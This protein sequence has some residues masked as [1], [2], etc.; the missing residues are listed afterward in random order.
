MKFQ[1]PTPAAAVMAVL[2]GAMLV[3]WAAVAPPATAQVGVA[4]PVQ[5]VPQ[6]SAANCTSAPSGGQ[7]F[8]GQLLEFP[9]FSRMDLTNANFEGATLKGAVFIGANLTGA[10]FRNARFVDTASPVRTTD[11]SFAR[12]DSACFYHASFAA[13]TYFTYATLTCT[14][15]SSTDLAGG[16]AI[17]GD[18]PLRYSMAPDGSCRTAFRQSSMNCEFV[19]DWRNFDLSGARVDQCRQ[20]LADRDFSNAVMNGLNFSSMVLDGSNFAGAN[21][22]RAVFT[23]ASLQ[24]VAVG[25]AQQC[26]DMSKAQLQGAELSRANLTGATLAGAFLSSNPDAGEPNAASFTSAHLK[27][28]NLSNAHLSGVDFSNANFF[29][30]LGS[31][32]SGCGTSGGAG[33][34]VNCATASGAT[35]TGTKFNGAYLYGVDFSGATISGAAFD[36]AVLVGANFSAAQISTDSNTATRTSFSRAYL[37]GTNLDL[38]KSLEANLSDAFL[39]FNGSGNVMNVLLNGRNHNVFPCP[40]SGCNPATVANVCVRAGY[41]L[42]T[43]PAGNTLITCPDGQPAGSGCGDARASIDPLGP[44]RRWQSSI[45]IRNPPELPPAWYRNDATYTVRTPSTDAAFC[46]GPGNPP[47]F[48]W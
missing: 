32:P 14:D 16:Q 43:V 20:Q 34:T 6:L 47:V 1:F 19:D 8:S 5:S 12:L 29:G 35:M 28:V 46:G 9:N 30:T 45:D 38:A 3:L 44:N 21:L 40:A 23:G 31:N 26:V 27:N 36:G 10:S 41:N 4:A 18:E 24:C 42:T 33:F 7:D 48:A 11:F 17:F 25:S 13:P 15:F 22:M 37:Q 39:D 2:A